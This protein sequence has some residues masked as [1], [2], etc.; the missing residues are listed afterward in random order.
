MKTKQVIFKSMLVIATSGLILTGCRKEKN[1]DNDTSGS[2]DNAYAEATFN[3][4]NNIADEAGISGSLSNYKT[5]QDLG[6]ILASSCA[7]ITLQNANTGNQDTLTIDFG[8][9]N[10]QCADQRYRRGKVIVYY[11]G[12]YKDSAST[13]TITFSNYFVDDNQISGTKTVT[14]KGHITNGNL[15]FDVVVNGQIDLANNAGTITWSSNRTRVWTS[16]ESTIFWN[17]D[18]YSISGSATGTDRNGKSFSATITTPLVRNMALGCRRHFV[19][20]VFDF[21]PQGKPTR[22]VDFG[23]GACDNVA[24]VTINGKTYTVYMK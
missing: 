7:T 15:T 17:D 1:E 9:N 20:G 21:V 12:M 2:S 19:S 5:G 18:V 8:P 23:N 4:V 10:C 24:T 11:S 3:D 16:G 14:N 13:H 22:T 6:G